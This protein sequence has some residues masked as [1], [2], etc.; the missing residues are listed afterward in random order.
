M[1]SAKVSKARLR[2]SSSKKD[3][4]ESDGKPTPNINN[5]E[6][7]STVGKFHFP[8]PPPTFYVYGDA[9]R[10]Q[11]ICGVSRVALGLDLITFSVILIARLIYLDLKWCW[12]FVHVIMT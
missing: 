6:L 2:N 4:T 5:Y 3:V 8:P 9:G 1:A 10:I 11:D 12:Q 7:L